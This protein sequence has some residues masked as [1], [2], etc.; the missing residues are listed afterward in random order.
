MSA[1]V[2]R[3][4]WSVVV[5]PNDPLSVYMSQGNLEQFMDRV[6]FYADEFGSVK[7]V[8][9]DPEPGRYEYPGIEVVN[10]SSTGIRA[11]D[12][13]KSFFVL[14]SKCKGD[15]F[16]RTME[17]G[18]F[19]KSA[20]LALAGLLA[21]KPVVV[22]LHGH[23]RGFGTRRGHKRW[24]FPFFRFLEWF[25]ARFSTLVFSNSE[26]TKKA[27][28]GKSVVIPNY[29]D[30]SRFR[31]AAVKKKWDVFYVGSMIPIKRI[32]KLV[33]AFELLRKRKKDARLL[34]AGHGPHSAL[35]KRK[36]VDYFGSIDNRKLP[37]YYNSSRLFVT[38]SEHESFG[39]PL[40]EA[41][42]CGIP[43]VA[44]EIEVFQENTLP[45]KSSVLVPVNDEKAMADEIIALLSDP[46]RM[47][48]MGAAGRAFVL[49]NFDRGVVLGREVGLVNAALP[50]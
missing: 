8:N 37:G 36:G 32:D 9:V 17:G 41:Q 12:L 13:A 14:L 30:C 29:I 23:Y 4:H 18:T 16:L 46:R 42:A 26:E 24:M 38:A 34:A 35:L 45:G 6:R 19:T 2:K 22:S 50:K 39:I 7:I 5:L 28:R 48:R 1:A 10:R 3:R 49:K 25:T 40:I 15:C 27:F 44:A 21:R 33:A 31:P 47:K 20:L 43:V 11:L